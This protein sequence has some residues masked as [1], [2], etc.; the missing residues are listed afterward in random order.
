MERLYQKEELRPQEGLLRPKPKILDRKEDLIH[1]CQ[2]QKRRPKEDLDLTK[3]FNTLRK[4]MI[5]KNLI[6]SLNR[7]IKPKIS[8]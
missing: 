6:Q 4:G 2:T 5:Q 7:T 3:T 8:D 1:K